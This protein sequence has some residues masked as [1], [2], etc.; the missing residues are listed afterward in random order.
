VLKPTS[1]GK[2]SLRTA[3]PGSKPRILHN[4]F[5]TEEDDGA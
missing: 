1:R 2:L 5:D 4:Y 3:H